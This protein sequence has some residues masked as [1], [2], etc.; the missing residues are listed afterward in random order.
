MAAGSA[1]DEELAAAAQAVLDLLE[2][3]VAAGAGVDG[4]HSQSGLLGFDGAVAWLVATHTVHQLRD[5]LVVDRV[6]HEH[7][8]AAQASLPGVPVA[9]DDHGLD[10]RPPVG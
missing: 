9:P 10:R 5:E 6:V 1:A 3:L 8:L 4:T 7:P 2:Q